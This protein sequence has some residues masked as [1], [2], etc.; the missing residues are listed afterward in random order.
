MRRS[1][2]VLGALA[3]TMLFAVSARAQ[4]ARVI[5]QVSDRD[6]KPWANVTVT[7][8]S[9][10]GRTFTVKTDK[11]GK[12]SQI[13]LQG[14]VYTFTL[15]EAA[16]GLNFTEKHQIGAD[17]DTTVD[18]DFKQIA[19]EQGPSAEQQ[20]AQAEAQNKFKEMA[21]H[22]NAGKAALDDAETLRKQLGTLA[23]DQKSASQD[24]I[25]SDYDTAINELQQA[26][27]GVQPKDTKNH[28][29]VWATLGQAYDHA[30]RYD[31]AAGAY[32]KAIDMM[33]QATYYV[34]LSTATVNVAVAQTDPAALQAKVTDAGADCD[35]ATALDPTL[36]ARCWKNI[37][38]VLS[39]KNQL[40]A[41]VVPLQKA[42]TADPKDAQA[43][44]LLGG[45]LASEIVTKQEGTKL[46]YT[47]PPGLIDAYQHCIDADPSGPY[48]A[49]AKATLD[50]LNQ[51]AGGTSTLVN[52]KKPSSSKKKQ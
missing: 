23:E 49:Q 37:G 45:A 33:P 17:G 13:G 27:Q 2:S 29:I 46:T 41:A 28:A 1:I 44:Y 34:D 3:L 22:F 30:G 16:S 43:W 11:N 12:Y 15:T 21:T 24:K 8:K 39:N 32:Q 20:K 10:T 5:G 51:L 25:K 6:G 47:F 36:T 4:N 38:I 52:E 19:A 31:D 40:A 26:E 42:T 48:A 7:M 18:F 50:G 9:D 14:G 35:K